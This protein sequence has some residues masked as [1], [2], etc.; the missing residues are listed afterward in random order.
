MAA[1]GLGRLIS[2]ATVGA[3]SGTPSTL[4]GLARRGAPLAVTRGGGITWVVSTS[5]R[6]ARPPCFRGR[7]LTQTRR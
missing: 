5:A 3:P 1:C 4:A 2:G 6:E 7:A